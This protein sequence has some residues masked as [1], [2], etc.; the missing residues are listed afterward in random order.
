MSLDPSMTDTIVDK[1][2]ERRGNPKLGGPFKD[3][4]DFFGFIG[5]FGANTKVMQEA[6]MPLFYDTE[7]NFRVVS[8]GLSANVK[9]EIT[10]VT[11][12][13]PNLK[14]RLV[15]LLDDQDALDKSGGGTGAGAGA[16][17]GAGAGAGGGAGKPDPAASKSTIQGSKGRPT[18]VYWEEN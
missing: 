2:I 15:K 11:Y 12:D 8:T 5:G 9:K 6:K 3:S 17:G 7:F 1:A 13:Y 14:P 16:G 10:V 18:V 4:A